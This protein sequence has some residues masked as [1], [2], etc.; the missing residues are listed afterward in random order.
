MKNFFLVGLIFWTTS[1]LSHPTDDLPLQQISVGTNLRVLK[2][3]NFPGNVIM[4]TF[5]QN[6]PEEVLYRGMDSAVYY[7]RCLCDLYVYSTA[8]L[9]RDR[10]IKAGTVLEVVSLPNEPRHRINLRSDSGTD[11]SILCVA[12]KYRT[13]FSSVPSF[14]EDEVFYATENLTPHIGGL[15]TAFKNVLRVEYVEPKKL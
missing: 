7:E 11:F 6:T 1:A 14:P 3:I 13:R 5:V 8:N 10:V 4:L 12:T 9:N 2:D 15:K